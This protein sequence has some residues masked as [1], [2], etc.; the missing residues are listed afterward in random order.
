MRRLMNVI[1]GGRA[2]PKPLVT[3]RFP[4]DEIE[5]AY[6]LFANQRDGVPEGRD[7]AVEGRSLEI[8]RFISSG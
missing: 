1:A 6:G 2:D 4:L 3:H 8:A 5:A 7:R